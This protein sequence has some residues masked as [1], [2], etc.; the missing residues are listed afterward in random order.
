MVSALAKRVVEKNGRLLVVGGW[1]RDQLIGDP[2]NDFDL[3]VFGLSRDEIGD[4]LGPFGF[5]KPVG[6]Q[7]RTWRQGRE[8]ID[9]GYPRGDV[10]GVRIDSSA[11][12]EAAFREASRHRDLTINA[13]GWDPITQALID[14]WQGRRDLDERL[15]RMVSADTFGSDPLRVLRVARLQ[16]RFEAS[17]EPMLEEMCR[18]LDLRD[19]APERIGIELKR[20]LC[21]STRPSLAFEFLAQIDQLEAFGPLEALRGTEQDPHWHPEGDVFIHTCLVVD[22]AAKI[23]CEEHLSGEGAALLLFAALCHDL[24]KPETTEVDADGR[25][26]SLG[27]EAASA[28]ITRRWLESLSLGETRL[29]SIETLVAHHLAP[30]QLVSQGAGARAYRRLA[31]KLHSGGVTVVDLERVARADHLGRTTE[32]AIAGRFEAGSSFLSR[33]LEADVREGIRDDVVTASLLMQRGIA[34]GP[35]LGQILARCREI[36]DETGSRDADAIIE[37]VLPARTSASE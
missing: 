13:I 32:D 27:H 17:V 11:S 14:P 20:I 28:A 8:R 1:V 34:E 4:L 6:R 23:V 26:R 3:E 24:G 29:R 5:S 16:A 19:L 30:G 36:Q 12:L 9:V 18:G 22:C 2:S 10:E 25:V 15:L 31:R 35:E 21:E 33:A 37:R 7:F